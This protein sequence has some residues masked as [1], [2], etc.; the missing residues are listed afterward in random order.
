[1][2]DDARLSALWALDEPPARDPGFE[3][4]VMARILRRRLWGDIAALVPV[5]VGLSIVAWVLAPV[6][7]PAVQAVAADPTSLLGLGV[8]LGL[9]AAVCAETFLPER[10]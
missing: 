4:A 7:G 8:A 5:V 2:T 9:A 6:V 10:R 1:M 3:V